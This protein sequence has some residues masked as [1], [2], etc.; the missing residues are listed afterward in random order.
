M[1]RSGISISLTALSLSCLLVPARALVAPM[2]A[3]AAA[4][5][6]GANSTLVVQ[7][8][9]R[10]MPRVVVFFV[11]FLIRAR[12]LAQPVERYAPALV[13]CLY[14]AVFGMRKKRRKIDLE[15]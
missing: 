13:M 15:T 1:R 12:G 11:F 14:P 7:Q 2:P 4:M 3:A 6:T 9:S 8:Y 10:T 5:M